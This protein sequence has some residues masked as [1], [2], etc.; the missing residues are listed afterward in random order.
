MLLVSKDRTYIHVLVHVV[1][2]GCYKARC[3]TAHTAIRLPWKPGACGFCEVTE[4]PRLH[5]LARTHVAASHMVWVSAKL[6]KSVR[7]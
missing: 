1:A 2:R 7:S 6:L 4:F 5:G 3:N